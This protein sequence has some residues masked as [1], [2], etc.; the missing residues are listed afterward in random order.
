MSQT[1]I[2]AF[3]LLTAKGAAELISVS[4]RTWHRLNSAGKVPAPVRIGSIVR[5]NLDELAA[6]IQMG[7]PDTKTF[8]NLIGAKY[9]KKI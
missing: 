8:T 4:K 1:S 2:D 5:W 7:C 3:K 9:D 6:W